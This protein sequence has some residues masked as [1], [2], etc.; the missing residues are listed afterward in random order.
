MP[1]I[2]EVDMLEVVTDLPRITPFDINNDIKPTENDDLFLCT[3]GFEDRSTHIARRLAEK[4]NYKCNQSIYFEYATNIEDNE[5]NRME[6]SNSLENISNVVISMECDVDSFTT[7]LR[8]TLSSISQNRDCLKITFDISVCSSKLILQIMKVLLDYEVVLRI[9]YSE[10][11]IYHPTIE[12]TK[13]N[14]ID[15]DELNLTEGASRVYPCNEHP[16]YNLDALPQAIIA[17]TTFNPIRT[18][19]AIS[20]IDETLLGTSNDRV[21]WIIGDPHL[22]EDKWRMDYLVDI[23][24][25]PKEASIYRISTFDYKET[26]INLYRIYEKNSMTYHFNISPLGS[27]MQSIGIALFHY[28][29]PEISVIYSP[30]NKYNASNYTEGCKNIWKID[31]GSLNDVKKD[32]DRIGTIEIKE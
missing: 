22:D 14:Q 11:A 10:A 16:G 7:S 2:Y 13:D 8:Q 9:V 32:M 1:Y 3:L 25:I 29:K 21:I 4:N 26:I 31:F 23:N 6:L 27:K 5:I 17:F 30:P 12:E 19:V 28:L 24:K 18:Q 20:Y 15:S